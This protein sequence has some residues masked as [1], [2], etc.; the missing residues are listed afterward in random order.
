MLPIQKSVI[1]ANKKDVVE[2]LRQHHTKSGFTVSAIHAN[3]TQSERNIIMKD[4]RV[5]KSRVLI[6]RG[7]DVQQVTIV[8]NFGMP[9]DPESYLH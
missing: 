7:I 6:A 4:I 8:I 9:R 5:G 1:F 2:H 3:L